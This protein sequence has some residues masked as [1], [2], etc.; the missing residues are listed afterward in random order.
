M[1]ESGTDT[2]TSAPFTSS[3]PSSSLSLLGALIHSFSGPTVLL[4][5]PDVGSEAN[6]LGGSAQ[7]SPC[8]LGT[9]G[10][11][12]CSDTE[13]PGEAG[14][15]GR[16]SHGGL[17]IRSGGVSRVHPRG[18]SPSFKVGEECLVSPCVREAPLALVGCGHSLG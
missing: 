9:H 3:S 15:S 11:G 13:A 8:L 6:E 4:H 7:D 18:C 10:Q 12:L 14:S 1:P 17:S 2:W 5:G 16:G